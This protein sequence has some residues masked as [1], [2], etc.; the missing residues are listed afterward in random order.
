MSTLVASFGFYA[1]YLLLT[2][3]LHGVVENSDLD[4]SGRFKLFQ[5]D[6]TKAKNP[7]LADFRFGIA[8]INRA[9]RASFAPIH[10]AVQNSH[11]KV[12][13][14]LLNCGAVV[15]KPLRL[16]LPRNRWLVGDAGLFEFS[17]LTI[18]PAF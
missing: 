18:L 13:E 2:N 9:D 15:E 6:F 16:V 4:Y 10:L 7:M 1:L 17:A 3:K 11:F 12:V 14:T 8:G 5:V